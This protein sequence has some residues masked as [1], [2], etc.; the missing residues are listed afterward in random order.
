MKSMPIDTQ[1]LLDVQEKFKQ[2]HNSIETHNPNICISLWN[3]KRWKAYKA[4]MLFNKL[5]SKKSAYKWIVFSFSQIL[6][7]FNKNIGIF[8]VFY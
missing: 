3:I 2:F 8:F 7:F 1:G 6:S 4:K 5:N